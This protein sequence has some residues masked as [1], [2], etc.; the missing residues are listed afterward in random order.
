LGDRFVLRF[1][2][3]A[4]RPTNV[5]DESEDWAATMTVSDRSGRTLFFSRGTLNC[6]A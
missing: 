1:A 5:G 6:G 2:K 4:R 3:T